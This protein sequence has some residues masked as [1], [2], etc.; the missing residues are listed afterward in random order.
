MNDIINIT[1]NGKDKVTISK[2]TS[3]RDIIKNNRS[4]F[5]YDFIGI[6]VNNEIVCYDYKVT[7]S[8]NI[9]TVETDDING[10]KM[11]QA[12]LKFVMLVALKELFG[13]NVDVIYDHSIER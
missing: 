7:K 2:N 10:Y 3:I 4:I 11:Y 1:I 5:N 12:G 8:I 9:E 13:N 6:K